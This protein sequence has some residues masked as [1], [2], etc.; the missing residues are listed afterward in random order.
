M[1]ILII[2]LGALGDVLRTTFIARGFKEKYTNC[3]IFWLTK[4]SAA[5]MLQGNEYVDHIVT[6]KEREQLADENFDWVISLDD[7]EEPCSFATQL[8]TKKLQGAYIDE[9]NKIKYTKD[10]EA[11]FGM[12][13]LRPEERGGK[14]RADELKKENRKTFQEIY[15]DM[16]DLPKSTNARPILNLTMQELTYGQELLEGYNITTEEKVIGVNTGAA[17]RWL[18]KFLTIE[19]SA[20]LCNLLKKKYPK[21]KILILGGVDERERNRQIKALCPDK[22]IINVEPVE[23]IRRFAS[24]LNMCNTVITSDS[25]ALHL[26]LALRKYTVVFFGPTSPWEIEMFGLGKKVYKESDCLCCYKQTTEKKPS[27]I[28]LVTAKDIVAAVE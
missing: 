3:T 22:N 10:V 1:K 25:L 8:K 11:W 17:N 18:L 2:K 7:E 21:S 24:I 27:C 12:G 15:A 14:K 9:K 5:S 20:E 16:F 4:E 26:A 6:W 13:I 28:D 19:K 23:D